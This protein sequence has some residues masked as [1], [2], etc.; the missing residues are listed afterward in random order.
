MRERRF[1]VM[2]CDFLAASL[3]FP[4]ALTTPTALFQ[5]N[6][7]SV[8][9]QRQAT[10]EA[11]PLKRI[12]FHWEARRM[13]RYERRSVRRFHHVVAVSE[14]DRTLMAQMTN[15]ENITVAPTGVDL[16]QYT[17]APERSSAA[18]SP[19]VVFV[20]SMDWEANVDGV[21]Y[22]HR[23]VWPRV[24][25]AVPDARF[26]VVGRNPH[27]RVVRLAEDPSVTV[28]GDVPS[29]TE[30]LEEAAVV[31]VPLRI[32]GGTRLKIYEA[33][34]V[35]RAVVSTSI[36]A[37]GLDVESG[38]DIELAD[39]PDSFAATVIALLATP[40]RR[41]RLE[42]AAADTAS[43]FSWP[44]VVSHFERSLVQTIQAAKG[45]MRT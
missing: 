35:G 6:V 30:H 44:T 22:F 28:T 17:R 40:A 34:A 9:W 7:E 32:G 14:Q 39:R 27:P 8:L 11:H 20:G 21:E 16:S 38:R 29:V 45:A 36:G 42:A 18:V 12:A 31:V 25:V 41:E 10:H 3:N 15:P 24:L 2:V 33:M 1:D 19:L 37:E 13:A 43:R 23:E 4:D 26:R 5:H